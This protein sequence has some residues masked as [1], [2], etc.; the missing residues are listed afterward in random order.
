LGRRAYHHGDLRN[1]L[2]ARALE[3]IETHGPDGVSLREVARA[4]GVN[5]RAAYRHFEDK[6]ALSAAI[7]EAGYAALAD[8]LER[9]WAATAGRPPRARLEALLDRYVRLAM[10]HPARYRVTFGRGVNEEGRFPAL[11]ALAHRAYAVLA[12]ATEA[13]APGRGPAAVR[14]MVFSLWSLAHGYLRL[15]WAGRIRVRPARQR[16]YVGALAAP[17]LDGWERSAPGRPLRRARRS[18]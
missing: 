14:D 1:A 4:V 3:L 11:G 2:L 6:R 15:V 12:G 16:R 10:A 7:A 18:R 17:L 5:H 9:S 13:L 8:A